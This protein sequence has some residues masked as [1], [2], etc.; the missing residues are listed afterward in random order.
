MD[1]SSG[2]EDYDKRFYGIYRGIIVDSDDPKK[3]NRLKLKV[4][5]VTGDAVTNWAWPCLF[6]NTEQTM[7]QKV[8]YGSFYSELESIVP[9]DGTSAYLSVP[10]TDI[11]YNNNVDLDTN[12]ITILYTGVYEIT[13][14]VQ[15]VCTSGSADTDIYFW[16][17]KNDVAIPGTTHVVTTKGAGHNVVDI[18]TDTLK[19]N[20]GENIKIG[21]VKVG[22]GDIRLESFTTLTNPT[23]PTG[24]SVSID[25]KGI[26]IPV[27]FYPEKGQGIWVM[28]EGGDPNFPVWISNNIAGSVSGGGQAITSFDGGVIG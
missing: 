23:R 28:Y 18:H 4:P 1:F 19:L 24:Y 11:T 7:I 8:V 12:Q 27:P 16:W 20:A 6:F 25:I 21:A 10:I 5:Q 14:A 22:T 13:S 3:L 9:D 2:T 26:N 17:L 15:L